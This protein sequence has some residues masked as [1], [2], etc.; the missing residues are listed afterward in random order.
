M[1]EKISDEAS[2]REKVKRL[3][4]R[5]L[6]E[7]DQE[8]SLTKMD[9]GVCISDNDDDFDFLINRCFA[10]SKLKAYIERDTSFMAYTY[11]DP[12]D[13]L[14][15]YYVSL[16]TLNIWSQKDYMFVCQFLSHAERYGYNIF[17]ILNEDYFGYHFT[18]LID[19][20]LYEKRMKEKSV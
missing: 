14:V 12:S 7:I 5:I 3:K 16:E 20:I 17:P 4:E 18:N 10:L 13:D 9:L 1:Y 2:R 15:I 11:R 6:A 19:R 8:Y